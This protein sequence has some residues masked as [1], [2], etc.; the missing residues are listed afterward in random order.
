MGS[1]AVKQRIHLGKG[2]EKM[3]AVRTVERPIERDP[4]QRGLPSKGPIWLGAVIG[5]LGLAAAITWGVVG[6]RGYLD[7]VKDLTRMSVPGQTAVEISGAGEQFVYYEGEGSASL[8]Q[9][10]ITVADPQG[11]PVGMDPYRLDL[12]Y[13][14]PGQ[15]GWLGRAVAT[16]RATVPGTYRVEAS[17]SAPPGSSIAIGASVARDV[18][19]TVLGILAL[20]LVTVGGGLALIIVTLV[21]R[22]R[23]R[24]G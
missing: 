4:M 13:D 11:N 7:R 23:A 21:R 10:G 1:V 15:P 12:R 3:S 19:P 9:L 6:V 18:I 5:V 17:G 2:E 8:D 14:P 16:F 24:I 22:S 20:L